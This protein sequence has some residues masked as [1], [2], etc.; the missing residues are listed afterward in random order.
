MV[1]RTVSMGLMSRL[2]RMRPLLR[3]TPLVC[4]AALCLFPQPG[5]SQESR[6]KRLRIEAGYSSNHDGG[7]K[8]LGGALRFAISRPGDDLLR[9]E[10][11]LIA[12]VPYAGLDAGVELRFPQRARVGVVVRAGGGLLVEDGFFGAVVRGGGGV[13]FDISPRVALRGTAQAAYHGGQAGPHL[14]SLGVDYRW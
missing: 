14:V 8:G 6:R 4:L 2:A 11:G 5:E 3:W 13:E 12:G 10:A 1:I 7:D 9:F